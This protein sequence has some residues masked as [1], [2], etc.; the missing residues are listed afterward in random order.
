MSS[1]DIEAVHR[2]R[3]T[4][5]GPSDVERQ[6]ARAFAAAIIGRS[7]PT[8]GKSGCKA[9]GRN[10]ADQFADGCVVGKP[11]CPPRGAGSI[12]AETAEATTG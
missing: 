4:W 11:I 5:I 12:D 2:I 6:R 9:V 10:A 8:P 3:K 1:P 7:G